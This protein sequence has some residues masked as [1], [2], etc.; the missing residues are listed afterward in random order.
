MPLRAA[1]IDSSAGPRDRNDVGDED[2]A[3]RIQERCRRKG[4]PVSTE[5][6]ALLLLTALNIEP[7]VAA[8]GLDILE[9]CI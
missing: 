6:V 4:L 5:D 8:R 1:V 7:Q 3:S 9:R 2:Y